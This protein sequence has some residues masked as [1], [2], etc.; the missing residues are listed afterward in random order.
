M[1]NLTLS[2]LDVSL[3]VVGVWLI[4]KLSRRHLRS[5]KVSNVAGPP[6]VSWLYGATEEIYSNGSAAT[7]EKWEKI[8][9]SVYRVPAALGSSWIV[10]LDTKALSH[11][12]SKDASTYV[13][14]AFMKQSIFGKGLMW[15][16]G[17]DHR[18]QRKV[19]NPLFN[20][21]SIRSKVPALFGSAYK[22]KDAW[23]SIIQQSSDDEVIID[24]SKWLNGFSIDSIGLSLFDH[25][26]G[27]LDGTDPEIPKL[28]DSLGT[29]P[30]KFET[31]I[32]RLSFAL[33]ILQKIPTT[34]S[35]TIDSIHKW[36][37]ETS[38]TLL[39]QHS[40][41]ADTSDRS[42]VATLLMAE[43][44]QK[45]SPDEVL[46]QMRT[47]ILAGYEATAIGLTFALMDLAKTPEA[48]N[49]LRKEIQSLP[50]GEPAHNQILNSEALPYLSAVTLETLRLHPPVGQIIR[51]A[52]SISIAAQDD[53]LPLNYPIAGKDGESLVNIT[54]PKG[55]QVNI[56][57]RSINLSDAFWGP[58]AK[59]FVPE[60]WLDKEKKIPKRAKE[61]QGYHHMLTFLDGNRMCLGHN[62]AVASI[63]TALA[64]LVGN[65]IFE[66]RDGPDTKVESIMNMFS[67][68]KVAGEEGYAMPLKVR[69]I[70]V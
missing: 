53:V 44:S 67:R 4:L 43:E 21:T 33:P 38:N 65:F 51:V 62:I 58:N 41:D 61:V 19:L 52:S 14:P 9:G 32:S 36:L 40:R 17:E 39:E 3:A 30:T 12:F 18:R 56:P 2:T 28:I 70:D 31:L 27:A 42:I 50:T 48:Q 45:M 8:Y 55:T 20:V 34:R 57:L 60:R 35:R 6:S 47:L 11:I 26:F 68:P 66:M 23:E 54:I 59:D 64:I 49:R 22:I 16:E 69:A 15:S 5:V 29:R 1:P 13:Q 37:G 10:V 63:K 46:T 7:H 24:I 25:D